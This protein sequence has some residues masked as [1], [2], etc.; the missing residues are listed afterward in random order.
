MFCG[1]ACNK[2][3]IKAG[4][5]MKIRTN[6]LAMALAGAAIIATASAETAKP[7]AAVSA[8]DF[9]AYL[10]DVEKSAPAAP[11]GGEADYRAFAATLSDRATFTFGSFTPDGAGAVARDVIVTVGDTNAAGVKIGE[12]RLYKGRKAAKGE[13]A[14]ERID[15]RGIST[16]GLETLIEETTGAY[17]KAII[18]GVEAASGRELG[19]EAKTDIA[20]AARFA[21]YDVAVERLVIDGLVVHAADRKF[22]GDVDELGALL[23]LSASMSRATTARAMI[24][25][26]AVLKMRSGV[27]K[28]TSAMEIAMPFYG[29]RGV[30]R[31]DIEAAVATGLAFSLDDE[32]APDGGAAPIRFSMRGGVDRYAITGV[33]LAKLFA[34]WSRGDAP[35]PKETNLMSLGVLESKNEYYTLNGQPFY[36]LEY[37]RTDLSSFNW[38]LPTEIRST[39]RNYAYDFGA[40]LRFAQSA[41]PQPGEGGQDLSTVVNLLDKH[42]LSKI[43]ASGDFAY[44]WAPATGAATLESKNQMKSL[45]RIDFETSAGLPKFKDFAAL[46]P[47]KGQSVDATKVSSLFADMTLA[48]ISITAVDAGMLPKLFAF[49][50]DMQS[51]QMGAKPGAIKPN[52]L[53]AGA[54]FSLRTLGAAPSPLSPVYVALGEF[55]AEGGTLT[56]SASPASPVPLSLIMVPGPNGEDPVTRLNLKARRSP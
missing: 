19:A 21:A 55:I 12:L 36:S 52:E 6:I 53:R 4:S 32:T 50:A 47:K 42:G 10:D 37:G 49:A 44:R 46:H 14:A 22:S 40:L 45:G 7:A 39:V 29:L 11:L 38:F 25:R 18:G 20:A 41:T 8:A 15:A 3:L 23:R 16:F 17:T 56:L 30:A 2:R 48:G 43:V 51:A 5:W 28:A 34:Y 27:D 26:G 31:G 13:V 54:A 33:K 35:P 24:M 1:R 9:D